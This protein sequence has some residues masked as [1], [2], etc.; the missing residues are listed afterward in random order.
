MCLR[1]TNTAFCVP[2]ASSIGSLSTPTVM[3]VRSSRTS[4]GFKEDWPAQP[5]SHTS[6]ITEINGPRICLKYT[7]T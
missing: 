6:K 3:P 1:E 4:T 2:G 5:A 7:E